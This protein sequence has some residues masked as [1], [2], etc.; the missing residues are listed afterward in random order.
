M[1]IESIILVLILGMLNACS[2][3]I[4]IKTIA[5]DKKEKILT[6]INIMKP[7]QTDK[8][9]VLRLL[10]EGIN[11]TMI[12]QNGYISSNIHSSLDNNYIIN[13]SQWK[14]IGDLTVAAELVNSGATPK[15]V[16]AFNLGKA[17]YHPVKL[18]AQY[19]QNKNRQIVIDSNNDLLT[20]ID[21]MTPKAGIKKEDLILLLKDTLSTELLTQDGYIS[22]TLLVSMDNS[23]VINYSQWKNKASFYTMIKHL[24]EGSYPKLAKVFSNAMSD[25]HPFLI[26]SKHLKK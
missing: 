13:Y 9:T 3:S 22:S 14:S 10:K 15:M 19:K 20:V 17:D 8:N 5:L 7:K 21:I 18:V 4:P 2:N 25:F 24:K 6:V 12:S 16:K 1:K 23:Y 26:A 11:E